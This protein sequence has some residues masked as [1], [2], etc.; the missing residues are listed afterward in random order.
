MFP[1]GFAKGLVMEVEIKNWYPHIL[2][3]N[4]VAYLRVLLLLVHRAELFSAA[5]PKAMCIYGL[6]MILSKPSGG[7]THLAYFE[8]SLPQGQASISTKY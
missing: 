6:V 2:S 8:L 1:D 5:S 3:A 7:L 4:P